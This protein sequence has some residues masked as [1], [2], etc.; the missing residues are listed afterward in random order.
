MEE[1]CKEML[2]A[3]IAVEEEHILLANQRRVGYRRPQGTHG[4]AVK[5]DACAL[6]WQ[7]QEQLLNSLIDK[8]RDLVARVSKLQEE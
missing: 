4:I 8:R 6:E 5:T 7:A 3:L 2:A 1:L